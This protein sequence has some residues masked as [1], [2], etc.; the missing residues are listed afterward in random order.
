MGGMSAPAA[1]DLTLRNGVVVTPSGLIRGG[2]SASRG[3]ITHVGP[4]HLL[5]AG[6][7]DL[8]VGG[9]YLLPGLVDPH[10]HLG[11]GPGAGPEKLV[12]DFESESADAASGGVTTM[13][14][15]TLFG[16]ESRGEVAEAAIATGDQH[17]L[18]DY[19]LTPVVTTREH[20]AEAA[21]L[22][23]LGVRSFKFFLGF[24]G[25][26]AESFGINADGISWDFFY[27]ACEALGEA[28]ATAFPTVHAEDPWVRDFLTERLR[29]T[30]REPAAPALA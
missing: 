27:Q 19:R 2:L 4:D 20:L 5:P 3:V 16:T 7:T 21:E 11:I 15:T 13:I 17:S 8:D 29:G 10:V 25:A 28:G 30:R 12:R 9:K 26:Q 6:A 18:V 1:P 14:T 24:K 22:V 23:K